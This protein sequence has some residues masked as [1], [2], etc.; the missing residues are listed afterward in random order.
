[1]AAGRSAEDSELVLDR[2]NVH[3]AGVQ[4]VGGAPVRTQ[5]LLLNLEANDVRIP[6]A[7][8]DV[9]DRHREASAFRM[10]R[11]HRSQ[12]V[13]RKRGDAAFARQV[14]AEKRDGSNAGLSSHG[15][16]TRH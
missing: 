9:I 16:I 13:G 2:H 5:V 3:L 10:A 15:W 14:V 7:A 1:M 8:L 6:I 11:R 4:E 12:Q